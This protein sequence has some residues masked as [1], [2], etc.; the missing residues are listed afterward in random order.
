MRGLLGV[1][2]SAVC[3]GGEYR[4]GDELQHFRLSPPVAAVATGSCSPNA[5]DLGVQELQLNKCQWH[6]S[7]A[8]SGAG[9]G[10]SLLSVTRSAVRPR[11]GGLSESETDGHFKFN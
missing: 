10:L 3:C 8:C 6:R 1:Q 4:S 9:E 5:C 11:P 2:C 7:A